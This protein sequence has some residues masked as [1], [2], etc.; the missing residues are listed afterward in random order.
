MLLAGAIALAQPTEHGIHQYRELSIAPDGSVLAVVESQTSLESAQSVPA[1]VVVRSLKNGSIVARFQSC[2]LCEYSGLT[3][4]ADGKKLAFIAFDPTLHVARLDAIEG[5]QLRTVTSI[6]GIA[7]TPRWSADGNSLAV[8]VILDP[9]KQLGAAAPGVDLVG[10]IGT[11]PDEKRIA[12]VPAAGGEL[13]LISPPDLFVYE[14]DW[15]PDGRRFVA[16]AAQGDG[17]SNWFVAK[18]LVV[19][20]PSGGVHVIASP[21]YQ[22]NFPRFSSDGKE[23]AFISGPMSDYSYVAGDLYKV[24]ASGGE[25]INVTQGFNGSFTG[26]AWR[27]ASIVATART[28]DRQAV[29]AVDPASGHISQMMSD[30]ASSS[31]G[32]GP[33]GHGALSVSANGRLAARVTQSFDR[34]AFIEGG[35]IA[36]MHQISH[37]ND[38]VSAHV[39]AT[40]LH[41]KSG[42]HD[43]QGWLLKPVAHDAKQKYPLIVMVHGGPTGSWS[44]T[45][46][47]NETPYGGLQYQLLSHGYLVFEPNPRGSSGRG[48]DFV[49]S[50]AT[51]FAETDLEDI[52]P[53]VD[54]VVRSTPVDE[55]RLGIT[56]YSYGGYTTM[57]AVTHTQRF[58]AAAAGAGMSNLYS[59]YGQDGNEKWILPFFEATP[60]ADPTLYDRLSPVRY[61]QH[62]H[63]PT[64]IYVGERDI[65]CPP[66]QSLE[67]WRA[68]TTVGVPTSLV[69]YPQEGHRITQPDHIRDIDMR[70]LQWFDRYLTPP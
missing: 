34:P 61:V 39:Q 30:F 48:V 50:A 17:D 43:I 56:G 59:N 68:L 60:Y 46:I 12:V 11:S 23:I 31:S 57:W 18:L 7:E 35:P 5:G 2:S 58:K 32:D 45:Y 3:W 28:D 24:D 54:Q 66:A 9:H 29:L 44:P 13:A 63:T 41:W 62:A 53:G 16:T 26:L 70:V 52:L 33:L 69:I 65:E 21:R 47:P 27:G 6:K 25:P 51:S 4:S 38:S 1:E 15:S 67:F 40:S 55:S 10:D 14:Y 20:L 37:E 22:M 19:D 64:F 42:E 36:N 49:K 8:L